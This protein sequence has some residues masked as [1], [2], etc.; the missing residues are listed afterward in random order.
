MKNVD[1]R[2]LSA[3]ISWWPLTV[4]TALPWLGWISERGSQEQC[5]EQVSMWGGSGM[6]QGGFF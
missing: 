3:C 6:F 2:H 4:F 1:R 5:D